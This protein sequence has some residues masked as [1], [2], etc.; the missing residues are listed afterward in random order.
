MWLAS[1]CIQACSIHRGVKLVHDIVKRC[2]LLFCFILYCF[3]LL[4]FGY[5]LFVC[6]FVCCCFVVFSAVIFVTFADFCS[7]EDVS[8][9]CVDLFSVAFWRPFYC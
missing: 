1:T 2:L 3:V 4:F 9:T 5:C 8:F 7:S 6:L